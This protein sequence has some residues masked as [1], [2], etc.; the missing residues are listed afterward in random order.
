MSRSRRCSQSVK[1]DRRTQPMSGSRVFT[2][3]VWSFVRWLDIRTRRRRWCNNFVVS[4]NDVHGERDVC[5]IVLLVHGSKLG[6]KKKRSGW[7][8]LGRV[9]KLAYSVLSVPLYMYIVVF[10]RK[11]RSLFVQSLQAIIHFTRNP[12][13]RTGRTRPL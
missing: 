8:K 10:T 4:T 1:D 9:R 7:V 2:L 11:P 13:A 3:L 5:R 6:K 12:P